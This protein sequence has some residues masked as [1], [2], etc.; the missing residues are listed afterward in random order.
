MFRG[1]RGGTT[2]DLASLYV[3]R[4]FL[5]ALRGGGISINPGTTATAENPSYDGGYIVATYGL[6]AAGGVS[7]VQLE[8]GLSYRN[9]QSDLDANASKIADAIISHLKANGA[10]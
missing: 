6:G 5:S 7:A 8:F 2:A 3:P 9:A 1:T 4:G 10:L